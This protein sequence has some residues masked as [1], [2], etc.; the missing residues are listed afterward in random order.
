MTA[1]PPFIITR[2][3]VTKHARFGV[4]VDFSDEEDR[5]LVFPMMVDTV[6]S[7][8]IGFPEV[9]SEIEAV[10]VGYSGPR[11]QPYLSTRPRDLRRVR[12]A[13]NPRSLSDLQAAKTPES[14]PKEPSV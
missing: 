14:M 2:G 3:V 12:R 6:P 4:F 13:E 9:G 11:N 10:L 5:V 8:G 7:Q 1:D